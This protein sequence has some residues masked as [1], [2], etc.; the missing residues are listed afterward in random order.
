M[1]GFGDCIE[2]HPRT[3]ELMDNLVKDFVTNLVGIVWVT[4]I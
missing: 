1:F 3:L 2:P 4:D